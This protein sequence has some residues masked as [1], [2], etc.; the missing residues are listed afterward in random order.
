MPLTTNATI[1]ETPAMKPAAPLTIGCGASVAIL[2]EY[3]DMAVAT[4]AMPSKIHSSIS[5]CSLAI[6]RGHRALFY[7][8]TPHD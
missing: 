7:T 2:D 4:S 1:A 5:A 6:P 8:I 3:C